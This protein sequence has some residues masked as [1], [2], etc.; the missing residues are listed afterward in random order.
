M[1]IYSLRGVFVLF[2]Y[3]DV[4]IEVLQHILAAQDRSENQQWTKGT[5]FIMELCLP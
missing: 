3:L 4:I 1:Q 2:V 5:P